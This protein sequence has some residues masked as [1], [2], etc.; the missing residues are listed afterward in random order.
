[1]FQRRRNGTVDFSRDWESYD[2][3]FGSFSDEFWLG[4]YDNVSLDKACTQYNRFRTV[5]DM[6]NTVTVDN[7]DWRTQNIANEVTVCIR[8]LINI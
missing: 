6:V 1:M 4:K 2:Q 8:L 5:I 3:G 7:L